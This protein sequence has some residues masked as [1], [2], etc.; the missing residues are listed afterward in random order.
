MVGSGR[1]IVK[2]IAPAGDR[3]L[4]NQPA[5]SAKG[6]KRRDILTMAAALVLIAAA[7]VGGRILLDQG[8]HI[9]LPAPPLLAHWAPHLG[10]GTPLTVLCALVGLRLQQVAAAL[11]WRRLLLA[12][13]LLNLAWMC[14]LPLVDGLQRA[15][16][17]MHAAGYVARKPA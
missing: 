16:K 8:R 6:A 4:E 15:A 1:K 14:S 11:M 17:W 5:D 3:D 9:V 13:W 10:W 12:G 7:A 2:P